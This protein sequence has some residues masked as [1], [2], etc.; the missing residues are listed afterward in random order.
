ADEVSPSH[1]AHVPRQNSFH[2]SVFDF[3][4]E[5]SA[6]HEIPADVL[7]LISSYVPFRSSIRPTPFV[8]FFAFSMFLCSQ[9]RVVSFS[10]LALAGRFVRSLGS[11]G[12]GE[13]QFSLPV[14]ISF[15]KHGFGYVCDSKNNRIQVFDREYKFVR[16]IGSAGTGVGQFV[17]HPGCVLVHEVSRFP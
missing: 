3:L 2:T 16:Q 14:D 15:D 11:G 13:G 7:S 1:S 17:G 9:W 5:E 4:M 8:L 12:S 6:L 10:W